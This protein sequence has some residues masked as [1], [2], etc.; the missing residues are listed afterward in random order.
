MASLSFR[1]IIDLRDTDK[2]RYF[3]IPS[4][5]IVKSFDHQICFLMI[6]FGKRSDLSFFTQERSKEGEKRGFVYAWAEYYLQPNT[7][8]RHRAWADHYLYVVICKSRVG[9]SANEEEE[10]FASND[11]RVNV[12]RYKY[13]LGQTQSHLSPSRQARVK[14]SSEKGPKYIYKNIN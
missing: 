3:A 9:L 10:K 1:Q 5:I 7:V 6:I 2:S 13:V 11:N 14:M 8:G 4:S 12:C